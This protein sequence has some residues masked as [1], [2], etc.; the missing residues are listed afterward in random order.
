MWDSQAELARV[1]SRSVN[2]TLGLHGALVLPVELCSCEEFLE[3]KP[4]RDCCR[5]AEHVLCTAKYSFRAVQV[6]Y[7]RDLLVLGGLGEKLCKSE[8]PFRSSKRHLPLHPRSSCGRCKWEN[9]IDA[10][11]DRL[12]DGA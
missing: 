6:P 4:L 7:E 2:I 9:C 5:P 8:R 3:G 12:R 10:R 1:P 11:R